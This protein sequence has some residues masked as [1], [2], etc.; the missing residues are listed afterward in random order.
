MQCYGFSVDPDSNPIFHFHMDTD[1]DK[2]KITCVLPIRHRCWCLHRIF[3]L[4]EDVIVGSHKKLIFT[5]NTA[6]YSNR[7]ILDPDPFLR[8]VVDPEK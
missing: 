5:P 6:V 8:N 3:V 4:S 2:E 7:S 1:P